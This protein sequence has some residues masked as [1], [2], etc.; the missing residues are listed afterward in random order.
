[1]HTY[2][3]GMAMTFHSLYTCVL[4]L[5]AICGTTLL[6]GQLQLVLKEVITT[7]YRTACIQQDGSIRDFV[8]CL[9]T[10]PVVDEDTFITCQ[11]KV[12]GIIKYI[13]TYIYACAEYSNLHVHLHMCA[14]PILQII[15]QATQHV[16]ERVHWTHR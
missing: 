3:H 8:F 6:Y 9:V 5:E 13:R 14:L 10:E 4:L 11:G 1:M 7:V 16:A 2:V 15:I 12:Q